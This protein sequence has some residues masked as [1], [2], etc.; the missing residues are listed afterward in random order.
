MGVALESTRLA[1][2][3]LKRGELM[4]LGKREFKAIEQETHFVYFRSSEESLPKIALFRDWLFQQI[5]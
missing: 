3:A 4:E 5:S 2:R 1:E